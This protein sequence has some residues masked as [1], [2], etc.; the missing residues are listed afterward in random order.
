[1]NAD[2]DR[3]AENLQRMTPEQQ[4][5]ATEYMGEMAAAKLGL[6]AHQEQLLDC[7]RDAHERGPSNAAFDVAQAWRGITRFAVMADA[8]NT[9]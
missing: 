9:P 8:L 3:A 5:K 1:M 4:Q 6:T 7:L 2:F